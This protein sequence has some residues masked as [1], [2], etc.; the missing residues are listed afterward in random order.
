LIFYKCLASGGIFKK[1]SKVEEIF[2]KN[3]EESVGP[4]SFSLNTP[5]ASA[6]KSQSALLDILQKVFSLEYV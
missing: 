6:F 1:L 4:Q 3:W 2:P 5:V